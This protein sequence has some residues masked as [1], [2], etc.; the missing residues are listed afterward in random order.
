M[1]RH[2]KL[3]DK[4]PGS[5]CKKFKKKVTNSVTFLPY[6]TMPK[7]AAS[8]P[9]QRSAKRARTS[10][11]RA[12]ARKRGYQRRYI[13]AGLPSKQVYRLKYATQVTL[14][15]AAAS[16]A[17]HVFKANGLNDPDLTG[18]GHQPR[19]W[20]QLK[21][22]YEHYIVIGSKCKAT[23]TSGATTSNYQPSSLVGIELDS[24]ATPAQTLT[25]WL[26]RD[27]RNQSSSAL[28]MAQTKGGNAVSVVKTYSPKRFYNIKDIKD[29]FNR[30]GAAVSTDPS[31]LA[32]FNVM[33]ASMDSGTNPGSISAVVEID[34]LVLLSEPKEPVSS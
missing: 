13:P 22:F 27:D 19:A 16:T 17:A 31:E 28:A 1:L 25:D 24:D 20:D 7:R 2:I 9:I 23:F 5:Y 26:E 21:E 3:I 11:Y 34:Y 33:T 30:L 6:A 29:N 10:K 32:Y 18:V 14:D 8:G 15:A 12:P 4:T